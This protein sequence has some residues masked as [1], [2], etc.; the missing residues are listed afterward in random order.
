MMG[1]KQIVNI[2]KYAKLQTVEETISMIL[3]NRTDYGSE[4][5]GMVSVKRFTQVAKDIIEIFPELKAIQ[6]QAK[7][8]PACETERPKIKN[9][10]P[11]GTTIRII[12]NVFSENKELYNYI[13]ALDH[14]I[15]ELESKSGAEPEV[16]TATHHEKIIRECIANLENILEDM[17]LE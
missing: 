2:K 16:K 14:Y 11:E 12:N 13:N 15:D 6:V 9:Y 8:E 1:D 4:S 5:G 10:F 17:N 7:V 3:S